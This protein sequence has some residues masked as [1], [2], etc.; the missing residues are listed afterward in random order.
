MEC[1]AE[2]GGEAEAA[3]KDPWVG[4]RISDAYDYAK[5]P[6]CGKKNDIHAVACS[7]CGN[8]LPQ[9]SA[10]VTEPAWGFVPGKG[11]FREGTVVE[12]A[13]KGRV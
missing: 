6:Q 8:E 9:P 10:E 2:K 11:Y 13:K 7:R 3:A 5:C 12:P 1:G 4:V